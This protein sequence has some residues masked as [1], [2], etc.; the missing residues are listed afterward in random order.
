LYFLQI[1]KKDY[2]FRLSNTKIITNVLVF[3]RDKVKKCKFYG[4]KR[5]NC[6]F[7]QKVHKEIY[8]I[9]L[10]LLSFETKTKGLKGII[11]SIS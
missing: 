1:G 4:K 9:L 3:S 5:A 2:L 8:A 7:L 10:N 6:E 11:I